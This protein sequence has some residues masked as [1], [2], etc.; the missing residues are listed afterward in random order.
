MAL[1]FSLWNQF[2]TMRVK[3][4]PSRYD[5]SLPSLIMSMKNVVN[6]NNGYHLHL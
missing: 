2:T 3:I 1:T 5:L 6:M 4:A